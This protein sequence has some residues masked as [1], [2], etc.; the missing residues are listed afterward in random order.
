MINIY[1]KTNN[2]IYYAELRKW[3]DRRYRYGPD[4]FPKVD[5]VLS[6]KWDPTIDMYVMTHHELKEWRHLWADEVCCARLGTASLLG[7][8]D[9][10]FECSMSHGIK[11]RCKG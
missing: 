10:Q 1:N 2:Q 7:R 11:W 5:P 3:N 6:K 8:G 4:M 9:Y